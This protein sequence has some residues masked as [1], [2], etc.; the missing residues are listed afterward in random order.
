MEPLP[1]L[2]EQIPTAPLDTSHSNNIPSLKQDANL[3]LLDQLF[4]E[5]KRED[6]T[7]KQTRAI[8]GGLTEKFSM[9]E[10]Q[11]VISLF[12]YLTDTW[13][14]TYEREVFDG[15]TLQELLNLG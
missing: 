9:D 14:D 4:P 8:L 2:N 1:L 10:L 11:E 3:A 13:L 7:V 6:K 12:Q 15:K 5:Q